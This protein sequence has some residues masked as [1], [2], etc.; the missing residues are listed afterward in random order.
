MALISSSF[1]VY[2]HDIL[3]C[4]LSIYMRIWDIGR[5]Y[6]FLFFILKGHNMLCSFPNLCLSLF[7]SLEPPN[8][9]SVAIP[10]YRELYTSSI[11]V[12]LY[13]KKILYKYLSRMI[14]VYYVPGKL[15][16]VGL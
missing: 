10:N 5:H 1:V 16:N 7:R 8:G 11:I 14:I 9:G 2:L 3:F 15:I 6:E 12:H 13:H 4:D